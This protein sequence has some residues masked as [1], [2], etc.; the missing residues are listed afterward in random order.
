M[1]T[2][3]TTDMGFSTAAGDP[4]KLSNFTYDANNRY[5]Q[6]NWRY[7]FEVVSNTNLLIDRVAGVE[8]DETKRIK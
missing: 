4:T 5:F 1:T 8:I 6:Y 2:D 3:Y 7:M